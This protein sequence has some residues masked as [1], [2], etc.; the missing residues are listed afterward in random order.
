MDQRCIYLKSSY[1]TIKFLKISANI[2]FHL[3]NYLTYIVSI[4]NRG[5]ALDNKT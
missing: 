1:K 5:L 3:T 4:R 2:F